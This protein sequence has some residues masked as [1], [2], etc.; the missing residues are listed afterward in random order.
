MCLNAPLVKAGMHAIRNA[1][2]PECMLSGMHAIRN[3]CYPECM[4]SGMPAVRNACYPECML[5]GMHAIRN[6]CYAIFAEYLDADEVIKLDF[7]NVCNRI[8]RETIPEVVASII[9]LC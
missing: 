8:S 3:A 7:R 9:L 4:L 6:A 5:S 1:C 2:Y